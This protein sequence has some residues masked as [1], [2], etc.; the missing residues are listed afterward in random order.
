MKR[1]FT[2]FILCFF[3]ITTT[4]A[5]MTAEAVQTTT[6][7]ALVGY[8]KSVNKYINDFAKVIDTTDAERIKSTLITLEC[9][10]GL[11][12]CIVTINDMANYQGTEKSIEKFATTLFN[13]WGIGKKDKNNGV[14]FLVALKNRKVRIELGSGYPKDYNAR[15]ASVIKND[16]VPYFKQNQ[17]SRGIYEGT[18]SIIKAVTREETWFE[19]YK[20]D[21]LIWILITFLAMV[22]FSCFRSGRRGWGWAF[23]ALIGGLLFLLWSMATSNNS[24]DGFGGGKSDGGGS[25]GDW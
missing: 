9:Q 10:T 18:M 21:I 2:T 23:I 8:P 4:A 12:I 19:H 14:L 1:F 7:T 16:I 25:S 5:S 3:V 20:W 13:E 17:Y 11:H 6:Q 15:M 24:S 22:V